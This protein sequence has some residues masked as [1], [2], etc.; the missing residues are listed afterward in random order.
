MLVLWMTEILKYIKI[1]IAL[2]ATKT[3]LCRERLWHEL[4]TSKLTAIGRTAL[5]LRCKAASLRN[6]LRQLR[7]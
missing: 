3:I 6:T 5:Y 7:N 1:M 2:A 4:R